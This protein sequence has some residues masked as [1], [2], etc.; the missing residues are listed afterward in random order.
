MKSL[1][2]H[3]TKDIRLVEDTKVPM[4]T[5][6]KDVIIKV[7]NTAICGSDLH[8]YL[9]FMPGMLK[10][11]LMGHEFM[12]IIEDVGPAVK[13]VQRGDRVV[14]AFDIA[15]GHC[16]FCSKAQYSGCD[17]TNASKEQELLYGQHTC[18]I[19]GYSHLTG[20]YEG[21][22][23]EYVRVPFADVGC[24]KVPDDV[25]DEKALLLSDILPT[26]WHATEL[27]KVEAGNNV[28][29]WGA[30]PVGCLAAHCAFSRGAARV[31][32]IDCEEYRLKFAKEKIP[33]VETINF[34]KKKTVDVLHEMFTVSG[35]YIGPDVAIEAVGFHY[36]KSSWIDFFEQKLGLETDPAYIINEMI[37]CVRKGGRMSIVG[38]YSGYCNG[39]KIGAFMEKGLTMAAGQCPVQ[40]YWEQLMELIQQGKLD[41]S[42]VVTHIAPLEKGPDMYKL[43]NDKKD[44]VVKVILRPG[45]P[46]GSEVIKVGVGA[47]RK[48]E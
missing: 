13:S 33:Q 48:E 1:Q 14:A 18:G 43:F 7:T 39:F 29:I 30:G 2:W 31:V 28:A 38:V 8:L 6:D 44:G 12:G 19:F 27:G 10:G 46:G 45:I 11:D 32:L 15:C 21:G 4:I 40:K 3:G 47:E 20:G 24:I 35:S 23:A 37:T 22:Q 41:P 9:G 42:F 25:P 36:T 5:D 34:K 17:S 16:F 26:A